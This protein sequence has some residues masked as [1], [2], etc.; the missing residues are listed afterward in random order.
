[1]G[2]QGVY[3]GTRFIATVEN[4]A[5]HAAKRA[6]VQVNSEEIIE[7]EGVHERTIPTPGGLK[8][9]ELIK[10]GKDEE[11]IPYHKNGYKE[12]L[13]LGNLDQG[14]ISVSPSA[15]GIQE[16]LTCQEV[17]DEIVNHINY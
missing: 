17:I 9:Y 2:A 16:I 15:G 1:M 14:T 4:P 12:A 7:L 5:S 6:I 8:A 10:E 11:A 13:L 3:M